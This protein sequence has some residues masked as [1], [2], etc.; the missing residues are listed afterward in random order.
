MADIIIFAGSMVSAQTGDDVIIAGE[1]RCSGMSSQD[2]SIEWSIQ[3]DPGALA[4]SINDAIKDAAIV[5]ADD[6][7]FVVGALDKKTLLAGAVG[8]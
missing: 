6:R 1:A 4:A 3:I 7:G 8:L 2:S 5:A